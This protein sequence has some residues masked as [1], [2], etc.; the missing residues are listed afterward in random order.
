M[1]EEFLRNEVSTIIFND[2]ELRD[3]IVS[4]ISASTD[5]DYDFVK[6]NLKLDSN[7]VNKNI[8]TKFSEVDA[9][10][11]VDNI[12]IN[13][14]INT[15]RS[16]T[17]ES[18]NFRYICNLVL[19]QVPPGYKDK[20]K[21]V[22]QININDYDIFNKN[23]FIYESYIMDKKYHLKRS[24]FIKIIDINMD[25]L[26]KLRY[27]EIKKDVNSLEY[28]L[29]VFICKDKNIID[30]LYRGDKIM[31][32]LTKKLE[33]LTEDFSSLYYEY[34]QEEYHKQVMYELGQTDGIKKGIN[35]EK[36]EI[37]KK[38][39][40]KGKDIAEIIEFTGLTKEEIE[41]L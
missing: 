23:D 13:I 14:E 25:Y 12:Y 28:L 16:N 34:D 9:L 31:D 11:Q 33:A 19:K 6:K 2:S 17:T 3:Y 26:R 8:N 27:N 4:V 39:L 37:A 18:K 20:I 24:E 40:A 15:S 30:K 22:Y 32:K 41:N 35:Q 36:K 7:K 5:L 38:M 21:R 29:Y 10:Y 1:K